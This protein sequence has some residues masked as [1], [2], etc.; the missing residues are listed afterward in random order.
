[1][2]ALVLRNINKTYAAATGAARHVLAG[3][4]LTVDA[5][6]FAVLVGPSGC[7]KTTLLKIIAGLVKPDAGEFL[8]TIDGKPITTP[9]PDRGVVFQQ[10]HS[11]PWL[12]VLE[13]VKFGLQFTAMSE[14]DRIQKAEEQV[15]A[16][17]LI[18]YR[19]EYPSVLSGGQQ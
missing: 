8:L 12:T 13:N 19:N 17:G 6:E 7:G 16:V 11:Y 1:M 9:G 5:G 2:A 14:R 15:R 4:D 18:D 3:I 10:Y